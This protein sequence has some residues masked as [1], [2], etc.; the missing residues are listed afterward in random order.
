VVD[1]A[2]G[3]RL[4][5][6]ELPPPPRRLTLLTV[7]H[8]WPDD[9]RRWLDSVLRHHAT[10]DLEVLLVVNSGD[11][12]LVAWAEGVAS[13][14]VRVLLLEPQGFGAAVN[15]GLR[16]AAGEFVILFDPGTEATGDLAT[17]LLEAL[18]NPS[19][20]IAAAFGV[21]GVGTVKHFHDHPGPEV[22]AVEG[23]C[24]A[25]RLDDALAVG[26]FDEKFR[27]YRIAD[28]EFSFRIRS[29]GKRAMVVAGLPLR[30]HRHR[31]WE[32]ES[33]ERREKL[34]KKNFY[35]FLDRWGKRTDLLVD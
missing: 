21:R 35:R 7:L 8:G 13:E 9:A 5:E 14:R 17:P 33:E 2:D 12:E 10:H 30:R 16:M 20:G 18:A 22:D 3:S 24:M 26:G 32:A 6:R 27:Y 34:S 29:T 15:A 28:F 25:F 19:V 1:T 11:P 31:L 23:Y 4:S